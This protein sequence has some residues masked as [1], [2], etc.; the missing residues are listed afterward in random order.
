LAAD[1]LLLSQATPVLRVQTYVCIR[2][3]QIVRFF[4]ILATVHRTASHGSMNAVVAQFKNC[5]FG[6]NTT[7]EFKNVN[8][9]PANTGI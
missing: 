9:T 7:I 8:T 3:I 4:E 6:A 2:K 5:P 1:A